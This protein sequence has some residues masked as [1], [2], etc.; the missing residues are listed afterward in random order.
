MY[1]SIDE[2]VRYARN[3]IIGFIYKTSRTKYSRS[4]LPL[5]TNLIRIIIVRR[6]HHYPRN[7]PFVIGEIIIIVDSFASS[8]QRQNNAVVCNHRDIH[9]LMSE[10][11]FM[12]CSH[13]FVAFVRR[14]PREQ[15][16]PCS[17]NKTISIFRR[18]QHR[19]MHLRPSF[20]YN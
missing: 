16:R 11:Y 10:G 15:C 12:K 20:A 7:G 8:M 14:L 1:R 19:R 2:L 17:N 18:Y 6:Y 5:F 13:F 4:M 9:I 3:K